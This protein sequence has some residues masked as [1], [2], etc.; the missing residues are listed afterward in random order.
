MHMSDEFAEFI[1]TSVSINF[2]VLFCFIN[3]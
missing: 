1:Q 2:W 3:A